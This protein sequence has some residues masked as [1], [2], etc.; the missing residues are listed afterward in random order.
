M[1]NSRNKRKIEHGFKGVGTPD[2]EKTSEFGTYKHVPTKDELAHKSRVM[3]AMADNVITGK[4]VG[5]KSTKQ[6]IRTYR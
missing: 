3:N 2:W 1:A 4:H 5:S 6:L